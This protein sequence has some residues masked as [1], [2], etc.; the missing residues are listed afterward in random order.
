M[1]TKKDKQGKYVT[2]EASSNSYR[3]TRTLSVGFFFGWELLTCIPPWVIFLEARSQKIKPL[4][5]YCIKEIRDINIPVEPDWLDRTGGG[6][7]S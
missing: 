3:M 6:Q 7:L 1:K 4:N 5:K 2:K